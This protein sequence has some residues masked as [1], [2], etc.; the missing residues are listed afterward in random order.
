VRAGVLVL[1]WFT[2][3]AAHAQAAGVVSLNLCA[4]QLLVLLAPERVAALEPLARDPALSFVAAQARALPSVRADAEAVLQLHP[5]LVLAG[6]YGAQ[7]TVALLQARG[8]RVEK[9]DEPQDFAGIARQVM[10]VAGLLGV[11]ARGAALVASMQARLAALP[12][13]HH[14]TAL[15]WE[16][17]G[18]SAGPDSLADAVLHAAGWQ[19]GGTGGRMGV[20]RI[21]AHRP[22]L[23]VTESAPTYPSMA[24]DLAWHPALRGIPRRSVNP[25]LL[26][27]G[28]PFTVAAAESLAR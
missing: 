24:T 12:E 11:P 28:G 15:F 2:M 4:D 8:L 18:W 6:R 9:L 22:D 13:A 16:A 7:T 23:L 25:A 17:G 21:L 27:C 19:N 3:F 10:Q 5:D 14:G 26:I 20:E 1:L